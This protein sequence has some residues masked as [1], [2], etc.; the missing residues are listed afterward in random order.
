[1]PESSRTQDLGKSGESQ[2]LLRWYD[3]RKRDL[4]WRQSLD[5]YRIWLSEVMLQQTQV[6]TVIPYFQAFLKKFP[7]VDALAAADVEEVMASWS[8]LGYYRRARQLHEAAQQVSR[9][10][11]FP[12]TAAALI[13][14]PGI[15]AYTAAAVAS[16]AFGEKVAVLDGNVERLLCRLLAAPG[17]PKKSALRRRLLEGATR[18]LTEERPGDGNQAMMELGA[19]VCLPR[20]PLCG[21]C[22]LATSCAARFEGEPERYPPPKQRRKTERIHLSVAI[23]RDRGQELFFRRAA[24][25]PFLPKMWELPSVPFMEDM[26]KLAQAFA[27]AYG[28]RWQLQEASYEVRH[29]ITY[30]SLRLHVHHAVLQSNNQLAEGPEAAWLGPEDRPRYAISSMYE[31]VLK[32]AT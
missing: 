19:T 23:V 31:K 22:P 21:E 26:D 12:E 14:L 18:L 6:Q 11:S 17:D 5:P 3:L 25:A 30:R 16:I 2:A 4:P 7:T 1:M 32:K 29:G 28:G 24:D 13:E 9:Q 10:G 8:G 20:K 27:V 15:G